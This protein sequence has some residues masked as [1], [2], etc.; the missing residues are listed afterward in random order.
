MGE[1]KCKRCGDTGKVKDLILF[2]EVICECLKQI[3]EN[4]RPLE[5]EYEEL[6]Q[7]SYPEI[8]AN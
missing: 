4:N 2:R 1:K 8:L 5:G 3:I 6:F 7:K